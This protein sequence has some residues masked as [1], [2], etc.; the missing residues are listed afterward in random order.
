MKELICNPYLQE[1][2]NYYNFYVEN[3]MIMNIKLNK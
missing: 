3:V 2:K 1:L